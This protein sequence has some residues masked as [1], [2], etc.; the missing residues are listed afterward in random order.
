MR[1]SREYDEDEPMVVIERRGAG[2]TPFVV[3]LA[4]GAGIALLFAPQSGEET[5]RQLK[6]QARRVSSAARD[7]AEDLSE[8]LADRYEHAKRSVEDKLEAAR[9]ALEIKKHQ[10]AEAIKAGREAAQQARQDLE[11]RIAETKAAYRTGADTRAVRRASAA[12][13]D[14]GAD[15]SDGEPPAD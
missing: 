13:T 3:G 6:R 15:A 14:E 1:R 8:N 2:I 4:V 11:A 7:A 12:P 5:R 9:H 10:A